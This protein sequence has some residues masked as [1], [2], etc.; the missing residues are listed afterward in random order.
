MIFGIV[1]FAIVSLIFSS[2]ALLKLAAGE[3][4]L[5]LREETAGILFGHY[6]GAVAVLML[7]LCFLKPLGLFCLYAAAG[8]LYTV[9][10][11]SFLYK[12]VRIL[13]QEVINPQ[14]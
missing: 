2:P 8:G 13:N 14:P 12:A 1:V 7:V 11:L 6:M 9:L 10:T 3:M 4:E 5:S